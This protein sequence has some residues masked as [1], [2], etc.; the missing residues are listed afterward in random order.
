ML[1]TPNTDTTMPVSRVNVSEGFKI[2]V[3]EQLDMSN[4]VAGECIYE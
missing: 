4:K 2:Y 1:L 3:N